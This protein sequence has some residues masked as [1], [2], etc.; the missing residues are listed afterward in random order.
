[1]IAINQY[2]KVTPPI[3]DPLKVAWENVVLKGLP[4]GQQVKPEVLHSWKKCRERGVDPF[5][6]TTPPVLAFVELN[7][8]LKR[9]KEIIDVSKPVMDM[10]ALSVKHSGFIITLTNKDGYVLDVHGDEEILEMARKNYYLPGCLRSIEHAGTNAIGV[11]LIEGKPIQITGAEHY[12]IFNH[13]WTCS[14]APIYHSRG[15]LIGA[16]TLSGKSIGRHEHTLAL[17]TEAARNI[18]SQLREKDLIEEKERLNSMLTLTF[19]SISD[20]VISLDEN[21]RVTHINKPAADM[22]DISDLSYIGKNLVNLV[23]LEDSFRQ[24]LKNRNYFNNIETGFT[25]STGYK[26]YICSFNPNQTPSGRAVGCIVTMTEKKHVINIAK[27]IS[28][29]YAKYSFNDIKG[30]NPT[31]KK[32]IEFAKVA[33]KT[34]SKILILGESGTGKELFAHAIH[35]KSIRIKNPFV[36]ISC[37]AIPRDIIEAELFGYRGGAFTGAK[38][39]GQIGKFELANKGTLFLDEIG[40]LP[41]DLQTKL[42]RVLQQQEIMRLGDTRTIPIDIRVIAATNKNLI[43]EVEQNNFREDLYYRL[44]VVEISIPPLRKRVDD[45]ELLVDHIISRHCQEMNIKKPQISDEVFDIFRTYKWPG[46]IRELENCL[47]R[48][49]LLSQGNTIRRIHVPERLW[50]TRP[51]LGGKATSLN[52]AYKEMINTTLDRCG[53]N[54]AMAA[55]ELKVARSTLYRKI[56]EFEI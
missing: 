9:N 14:S 26:S 56:R 50:K 21:L 27:R 39:E 7:R 10:I 36:A 24:A 40:S 46:N 6:K 23:Q 20:G 35:K 48:A 30:N 4:P 12:K 53:G 18:E 8:L 1:M 49:L 52:Q 37:A 22:L 11:C 38:R 55:R 17:V 19:N 42:L 2:E 43:T 44:S 33:S 5:T 32:K 45:L 15:R 13:P 51:T 54:K 25:C 41:L 34:N 29:N 28:G 47:E 3:E 16:L 31:L